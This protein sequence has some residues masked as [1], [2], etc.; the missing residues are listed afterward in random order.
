M[1][2]DSHSLSTR[3]SGLLDMLLGGDSSKFLEISSDLVHW[4]VCILDGCLVYASYSVVGYPELPLTRVTQCLER[5]HH[6]SAAAVLAKSTQQTTLQ[7]PVLQ[8]PIDRQ[9]PGN[10]DY[11]ALCWLLYHNY[12]N[13][14][15]AGA[16]ATQLFDEAFEL[17]C[18]TDGPY[19]IVEMP[20]SAMQGL[21][22]QALPDN[23]QSCQDRLRNCHKLS[24]IIL[25]GYQRLYLTDEEAF[26]SQNHRSEAQLKLKRKLV[27]AL[28][29]SYSFRKL[30]ALLRCDD[31]AIAKFLYPYIVMNAIQLKEPSPPFIKLPRIQPS[32]SEPSPSLSQ[33]TLNKT[34]VSRERPLSN[35]LSPQSLRQAQQSAGDRQAKNATGSKTRDKYTIVCVDDSPSI[36]NKIEN[37]LGKNSFNIFKF[38]QPVKA[39]VQIK[40]LNADLIF[41]DINMPKMN[42]YELCKMLKSH[43][44][45]H[46]T[47]VIMLTGS[48]D[49]LVRMKAR[50]AGASDYITKPFTR[51]NLLE[52]IAKHIRSR[53]LSLEKASV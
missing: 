46:H 33:R 8:S 49:A 12:V 10:L 9:F 52:A 21:Y 39:I 19:Q 29:R 4:K 37:T 30:A 45:T 31:L 16:L 7:S 38:S 23:I 20:I 47:P 51:A 32:F 48:Q 6:K 53:K 43:P 42:G 13:R 3:K 2:R 41:L 26:L 11:S 14:T 50:A 25:S 17:L 1:L 24:P 35:N 5:S 44:S 34:P 15:E 22:Q 27:P 36:L 28:E 40:K 18:I